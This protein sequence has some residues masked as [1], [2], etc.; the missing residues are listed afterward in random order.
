MCLIQLAGSPHWMCYCLH[1][2]DDLS[3]G[4]LSAGF[5]SL[6]FV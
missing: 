5:M 6:D 4:F 3:L 1:L 2:P